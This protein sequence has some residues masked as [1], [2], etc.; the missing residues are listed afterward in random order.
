MRATD[1]EREVLVARLRE[2]ADAIAAS[3][4]LAA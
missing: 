2:T 1:S 3:L 4:R